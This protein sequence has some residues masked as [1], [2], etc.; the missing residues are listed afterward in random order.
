[1]KHCN[2][3]GEDD[4]GAFS[5]AVKTICKQCVSA[6]AKAW[7]LANPASE[8]L[9]KKCH[10]C[11]EDDQRAFSPAQKTIC[12]PCSSAA[13]KAW[14][15]ANPGKAAARISKWQKDNPDRV[16]AKSRKW[17]KA[18]P[19]KTAAKTARRRAAKLQRTPVWHE[20]EKV[21]QLY[22]HCAF[23]SEI[24]GEKHEVDHVIPLQGENVSGFHVWG[25]LQILPKR[26]HKHKGNAFNIE[27]YNA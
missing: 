2:K 12:K 22:K 24:T 4:Q 11:G 20:T 14:S 10:K 8:V 6:R 7:Y 19:D 26:I 27:E 9:D 1:M 18:N 17:S 15:L 13:S 25:N 21:N 3:C 23:L 16:N 5:P